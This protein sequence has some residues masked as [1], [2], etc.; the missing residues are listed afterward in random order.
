ML[1]GLLRDLR[2]FDRHETELL[3][4]QEA[5]LLEKLRDAAEELLREAN[6]GRAAKTTTKKPASKRGRTNGTPQRQATSAVRE[7]RSV[8]GG[9]S[10]NR[11]ASTPRVPP[12]W[13]QDSGGH[14]PPDHR[15]GVRGTAE[16]AG[17]G[18]PEDHQSD[19]GAN[20][21]FAPEPA[22]LN[23]L[24]LRRPLT[25]AEWR[26]LGFYHHAAKHLSERQTTPAELKKM[27]RS[28]F[29][30][31]Q[32]VGLLSLRVC[33]RLLGR[34]LAPP[35]PN[36]QREAWMM[37]GV[38]PRAARALIRAG[39]ATLSDLRGKSREDLEAL[40]GVGT[41]VISQLEAIQGSPIPVR[42]HYWIE[43]GLPFALSKRL[44]RA[45]IYNV[46]DFASLTRESF[47]AIDGLGEPSLKLCETAT[48]RTLRSRISYWL[49]QGVS[50]KLSRKLTSNEITSVKTLQRLGPMGLRRLGFSLTEIQ[51]L[52]PI[53]SL[54]R[55]KSDRE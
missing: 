47:L 43:L 23:L 29:L 6:K 34:P 9:E 19:E 26:Q 52:E 38:P 36:A 46:A 13:Q 22:N 44:V 12:L 14:L 18:R 5:T 33:E 40:S 27:T 16:P 50:N 7:D 21:A 41:K 48:R 32:G 49:T 2:V 45:G 31:I 4:P 28:D 54:R 11:P 15:G 39:I 8:D 17:T 55:L 25:L 3:S 35:H 1:S 37:R 42:S 20:A 51:N 24:A 30:G 53:F 10:G